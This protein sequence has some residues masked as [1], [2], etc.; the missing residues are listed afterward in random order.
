M[1]SG[2]QNEA[3]RLEELRVFLILTAVIAP[4]IAVLAVSGYGFLVW[5]YQLALGPPTGA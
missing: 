1:T 3:S 2:D 5:M 4:V